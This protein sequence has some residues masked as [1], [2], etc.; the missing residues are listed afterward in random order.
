MT[1]LRR[2]SIIV[3]LAVLW[4]VG[5]QAKTVGNTKPV[6]ISIPAIHVSTS[7]EARGLNSR[8]VMLPPTSA[9]NVVWYNG[10][11]APG[12]P[13]SAIMYGHLTDIHFKPAIFSNL[14]KVKVK[15]EV[16]VSAADGKKYTYAVIKIDTFR[17]DSITSTQLTPPTKFSHLTLYTCAGHWVPK[18]GKYSQY[19]VVYTSLKSVSKK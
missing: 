11:V 12:Q 17:S 3:A 14:R 9:K 4:P 1:F 2:F 19:L 15:D 6:K 16:I 18:L 5:L 13:G 10:G 8:K 7:V